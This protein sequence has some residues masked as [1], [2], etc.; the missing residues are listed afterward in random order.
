MTGLKGNSSP[1]NE[2]ILTLCF[3]PP[4]ADGESG[5]VW[6]S[7]KHFQ[8]EFQHSPEQLKQMGTCFS[9]VN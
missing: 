8:R 3:R 1:K 6:Y 2:K 7:A 5:E 9:N 4:R